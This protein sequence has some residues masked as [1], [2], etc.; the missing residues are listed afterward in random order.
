MPMFKLCPLGAVADCHR[1]ENIVSSRLE[2]LRGLAQLLDQGKISQREYEVI[3]VEILEAPPDEWATPAAPAEISPNGETAAAADAVTGDEPAEEPLTAITDWVEKAKQVP[4]IYWA[5]FG[6]SALTLLLG[7][8]FEP[9]SWVTAVLGAVALGTNKT[10]IGRWM[11][12]G[13]VAFGVAFALANMALSGQGAAANQSEAALSEPGAGVTAEPPEGS[14]GIR[15]DDLQQGWNALDQPPLITGGLT[16]TPESGPLHS[17]LYR[18]DGSALVAGAYSPSDEHV[19]ALMVRA[20][21]HHESISNMYIHVCYLLHPG[22]QGC[23]DAFVDEGD[24]FGK[25]M[26]EFAGLSHFAT[27]EFEGREWR[28]EIENDVETIRV[29]GSQDLG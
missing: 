5:A 15:L 22:S 3:K 17:F 19:Y 28:L 18:F 27:W 16:T 10:R 8:A 2:D 24:V 25:S 26:A 23:L 12:W 29:L 20:G 9:L 6:A 21:I 1:N 4:S 7:A 13:A 14:L 11:A